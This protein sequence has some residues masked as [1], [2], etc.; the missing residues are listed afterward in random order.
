MKGV[1]MY[2]FLS[3]FGIA[4]VIVTTGFCCLLSADTIPAYNPVGPV[5]EYNFPAS[6]SDLSITTP[7]SVNDLSTANHDGTPMNFSGTG[8]SN[9]V[10]AGMSGYSMN[11]GTHLERMGVKTA[12]TLLL[13]TRDVA[14]YGGF[15]FDSWFYP[16]EAVTNTYYIIISYAG[17]ENLALKGNKM[18]ANVSNNTTGSH[19][20]NGT[21]AV[22]L[23]EWHHAVMVFDTLGAE[24]VY[25]KNLDNSTYGW[26]VTG[27]FSLYLDDTLVASKTGSKKD[28]Q[29]DNRGWAFGVGV[30]ADPTNTNSSIFAG[31]IYNPKVS[32]LN[33]VPEPSTFALLACGLLGLLAYAWRKRR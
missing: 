6:S 5:F 20:I 12:E 26:S 22:S 2:K 15:V 33:A 27:T 32:F 9:N 30:P 4:A 21:T 18:Y 19:I 10:P 16:T 23:N 25:G 8:L 13:N 28:G 7:G 29:G 31:L 3:R 24:A 1:I 17:T 14:K 11:C